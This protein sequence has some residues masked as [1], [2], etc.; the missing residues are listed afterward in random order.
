[1]FL[2]VISIYV[3]PNTNDIINLLQSSADHVQVY[4]CVWCLPISVSFAHIRMTK[5][6][7]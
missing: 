7:T 4:V 5:R 2:F 1:M 3:S 6:V